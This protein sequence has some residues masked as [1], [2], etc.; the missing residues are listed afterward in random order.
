MNRFF[1]PR[2]RWL[3]WITAV[4]LLIADWLRPVS[5]DRTRTFGLILVPLIWFG[6]IALVWRRRILR[7]GLMGFTAAVCLFLVLPGRSRHNV[8]LLRSDFVAGLRRYT[9]V[10]YFWGGESPK[11]IDC[12]GLIRRGLIDGLF[13]RGVRDLDPGLV[14]YA[15]WVW[16][17]DCT[18]A[19]FGGGRGFTSRCFVIPSLNRSDGFPILPGDLAVTLS[20]N[21]VLA[22]MGSGLWISADPARGKVVIETAATSQNPYCAMRMNIVRWNI[23]SGQEAR[24]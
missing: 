19:D 24:P 7:I 10:Q 23:L 12:S 14:R 4:L 16:W 21:H 20:G 8:G 18:A 9:G 13:L 11:G 5:D 2:L 1:T 17:N 6:L 15:I 3:L 22:Y